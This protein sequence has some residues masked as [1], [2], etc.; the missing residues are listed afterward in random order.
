[1]EWVNLLSKVKIMQS[2]DECWHFFKKLLLP[3][4]NRVVKFIIPDPNTSPMPLTVV[5]AAVTC[6]LG[7]VNDYKVENKLWC[8][9]HTSYSIL[10]ARNNSHH[11]HHSCWSCVG[12]SCPTP[13]IAC[14]QSIWLIVVLNVNWLPYYHQPFEALHVGWAAQH[15]TSVSSCPSGFISGIC[16]SASSTCNT[17]NRSILNSEESVGWCGGCGVVMWCGVWCGRVVWVCGDVVW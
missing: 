11:K 1:M 10:M 5:F 13:T 9:A 12:T 14:V 6:M 2:T 8:N 3:L 4:L 15:G 7:L 16:W 17:P